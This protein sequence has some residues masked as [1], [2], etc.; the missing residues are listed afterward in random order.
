MHIFG[1]KSGEDQARRTIVLVVT[2]LLALVIAG[3]TLTPRLLPPPT[4]LT[5]TDKA[6][7]AL[8]FAALVLPAATFHAGSLLWIVPAG[9]LYG[10]LIELIQPSVGR[11][12]DP[13]DWLADVVGIAAG[14][15]LGWLLRASWRRWQAMRS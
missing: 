2:A 4:L 10:G 11:T 13:L 7:H 3:L 15:A 14:V 12:G 8:A 9:V 1:S 5:L 6:W